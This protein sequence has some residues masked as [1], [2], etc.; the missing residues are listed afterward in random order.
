MT[1]PQFVP[2]NPSAKTNS[3][4]EKIEGTNGQTMADTTLHRKLK[5]ENMKTTK[6]RE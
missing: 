2:C 5:I 4:K 1:L 6:N 3:N